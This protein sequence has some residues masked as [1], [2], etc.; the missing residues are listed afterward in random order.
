[1]KGAAW[2][3]VTV[4]TIITA[5]AADW[6]AFRGPNSSGVGGNADLPVEFGPGKNQIWKTSLPPG[7]SSPVIVGSRIFL[8]AWEGEKLFTFALD[9]ATGRILWR[10]EAPRDRKQKL[11]EKNSPA[12]PS[13]ASDGS[14]V[15][16]FFTDFGLLSYGPD[17]GERWRHPLPTF[18][19]PFG[20][21]ASP[22][23]TGDTLLLSCDQE[24]GSY[25]LAVHKDTGKTKW[26]VERPDYT[27]GF[28]TPVLW[29]PANGPLQA[30]LAGS[31]RLTAYEVETGKEAWFVR[32]LTW[33]LKPTPVLDGDR[34][35]VLGWAGEADPGQQEQIPSFE[36]SLAKLDKDKDGKL[37][38]EEIGNPKLTKQWGEL[39]LD[40]DGL[41]GARDWAMYQSKRA[42]VNG[43]NAYKLGGAGDMTDRNHLW[44][45]SR[46]L[47]NA[48]SPLLY[49]G[50]LYMIKDGGI[51]TSLDPASGNVLKQARLSAAP[52]GYYSSPI[53][54][55]GRIYTLSE[56]GKLSVIRAGGE[57]EP[58]ATHDF[59]ESC[60]ATPAIADG[61][62]YV[63]TQ[64]ALYCFGRPN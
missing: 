10:R 24:T 13:A 59:D 23:L 43:I 3:A 27:R 64:S 55:G 19:N 40:S 36:E 49:E 15:Y 53:G 26:R 45:Y 58:L 20:Q 7:H 16:V 37:S 52:G 38:Q 44:R 31:Y 57:W 2:I 46:S 54:A 25:F 33:Q 21:G 63:R 41:M 34:I 5:S 32:G 28:S 42:V 9:S 1:M 29:K 39:D 6:P 50:V 60:H 8:T 35:Y 61:R 62:I 11:H 4:G 30:L 51:L 48:T 47:P 22:V 12:S 56:E 17:G 14:N 18:N